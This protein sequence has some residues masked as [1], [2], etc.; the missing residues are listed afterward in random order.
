M[1]RQRDFEVDR[2]GQSHEAR[3]RTGRIV[4]RH[5]CQQAM[6]L[7]IFDHPG[8]TQ[9]GMPLSGDGV[10]TRDAGLAKVLRRPVRFALDVSSKEGLIGV[11]S[12]R[13]VGKERK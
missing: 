8:L 11:G 3:R 2:S 1:L 9:Y 6:S 4:N 12:E 7:R 13:L 5:L 10:E